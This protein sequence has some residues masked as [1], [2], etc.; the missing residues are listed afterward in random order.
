MTAFFG[1]LLPSEMKQRWKYRKLEKVQT[2][3]K[4]QKQ[5][6]IF[7]CKLARADLMDVGDLAAKKNPF[8]LLIC[9][10][11]MRSTLV[12]LLDCSYQKS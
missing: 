10:V 2:V 7:P 1:L 9:N 11:L 3:Q 4:V 5:M 12:K 8:D 6:K